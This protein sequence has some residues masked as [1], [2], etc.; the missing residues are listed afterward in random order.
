MCAKETGSFQHGFNGVGLPLGQLFL[1]GIVYVS[2][3]PKIDRK[4]T[5]YGDA[6]LKIILSSLE[7]IPK[8]SASNI[9]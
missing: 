4:N 1:Y 5:R 8:M 6:M 2:D 9:S 3:L 7:S